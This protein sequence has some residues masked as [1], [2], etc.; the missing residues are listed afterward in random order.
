MK[1]LQFQS[2]YKRYNTLA[3]KLALLSIYC[4]RALRDS[5]TGLFLIALLGREH[6]HNGSLDEMAEVD[7]AERDLVIRMTEI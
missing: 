2:K 5:V 6:P 7:H 3:Q 4:I 1:L